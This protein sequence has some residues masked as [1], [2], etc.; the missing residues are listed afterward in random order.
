MPANPPQRILV[1]EDDVD[2]RRF[3]AQVL[4]GCGYQVHAAGDGAAGWEALHSNN[5]DLLITDHNMPKVTGLELVKKVRFARMTLPVILATGSL[6][7]EELERHPYLQL[8]ATLLKPFS[9]R[10]LLETVKAVL[11]AADCATFGPEG[12]GPVLVNTPRAPLAAPVL[13]R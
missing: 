10:Q 4:A 8:A 11:C 5:F 1:V 2:L 3:N 13:A 12:C 9:P 6:P 7:T